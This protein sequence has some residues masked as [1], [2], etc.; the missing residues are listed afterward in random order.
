MKVQNVT[1]WQ[2][3]FILMLLLCLQSVDLAVAKKPK[4]NKS[5]PE[6]DCC[7]VNLNSGESVSAA[8][9]PI[10]V[11]SSSLGPHISQVGSH[12]AISPGNYYLAYLATLKKN[13]KHVEVYTEV[14]VNFKK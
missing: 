11:D 10:L 9:P 1:G 4:S 12:A 13:G 14:A 3:V 8:H 6:P 2:R 7:A 5:N